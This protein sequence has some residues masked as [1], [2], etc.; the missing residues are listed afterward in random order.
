MPNH[1]EEKEEAEDPKRNG[2]VREEQNDASMFH[3]AM[4]DDMEEEVTNFYFKKNLH[5][6]VY[7]SLC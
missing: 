2:I 4:E 6:M 7:Y 3:M 1:E 5:E